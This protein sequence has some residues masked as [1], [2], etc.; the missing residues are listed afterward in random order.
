[1]YSYIVKKICCQEIYFKE[2]FRCCVFVNGSWM[3]VIYQIKV[4]TN[5]G[6]WQTKRKKS[7]KVKVFHSAV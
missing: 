7:V 4:E 6:S 3:V 1:M 2:E 5:E